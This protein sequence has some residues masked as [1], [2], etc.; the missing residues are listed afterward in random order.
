MHV[1]GLGEIAATSASTIAS[2]HRVPVQG[3]GSLALQLALVS[4][5]HRHNNK[6]L[7]EDCKNNFRRDAAGE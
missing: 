4:L 3:R 7:R 5:L 2:R 1:A 6:Y